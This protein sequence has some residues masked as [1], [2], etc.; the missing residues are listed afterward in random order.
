[1]K[2]NILIIIIVLLGSALLGQGENSF[3]NDR[4]RFGN[5]EKL[6]FEVYYNYGLIYTKVGNL[7]L[8]ADSINKNN[9]QLYHFQ[10]ISSSY[11]IWDKL[12]HVKSS[13]DVISD[14]KDLK[15]IHY[16]QQTEFGKSFVD[17]RYS[18]DTDSVIIDYTGPD[19]SYSFTKANTTKVF[20][21]LSALYLARDYNFMSLQKGDSL[22]FDILHSDQFFSQKIYYEGRENLIDKN[23]EVHKCY[24]FSAY[25]KNNAIIS[26]SDKAYV[27]V[28][29]DNNRIPLKI[30][31]KIPIG[32]IDIIY[33]S[34]NTFISSIN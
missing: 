16:E 20:D 23:N 21:A 24:L 6:D 25:I 22:S 31:V 13:Y 15:P 12:Y 8:K 28:S 27:W 10:S 17:Y 9:R 1:M 14:F 19:T 26:D 5:H 11:T 30:S 7:V 33:L 29:T 34:N 32:R 4:H 18:F 2:S 3:A